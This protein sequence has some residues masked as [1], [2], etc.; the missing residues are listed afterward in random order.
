MLSFKIPGT[1][2]QA[3]YETSPSGELLTLRA[4]GKTY[5]DRQGEDLVFLGGWFQFSEKQLGRTLFRQVKSKNKHWCESY[6]WDAQGLLHMVDGTHIQR[7]EHGAITSCS[8]ERQTWRYHYDHHQLVAVEA[9]DTQRKIQFDAA[10]RPVSCTSAEDAVQFDYG[11]CGLRRDTPTP[12]AGWHRDE[13]GRLWTI[14]D[15]NGQIT[16]TYLWW[17]FACLA[18]IDGPPGDD[19]A[20]VFSLDPTGTPVRMTTPET[21]CRFT[22]DAFGESLLRVSGL[23]GLFGGAQSGDFVH[24]RSRVLD[25]RIGSFTATDPWHGGPDDPRREKGF[26]GGLPVEMAP[27]G[28]YCV[29]QHDPVARMDPTGEISTATAA[30]FNTFFEIM[31]SLTWGF[32][33]NLTG[34]TLLG[35]WNVVLSLL[36]FNGK[37][38]KRIGDVEG[39]RS[40]YTGSWGVRAHPSGLELLGINRHRAWTVQHIIWARGEEFDE[41]A[42]ARVFVPDA[43]F[44]PKLTGSLLWIKPAH[45]VK[46]TDPGIGFVLCGNRRNAAPD[47][48][49]N[50][51]ANGWTRSGGIGE[52]VFEGATAPWFPKGGLHFQYQKHVPTPV[53]G[54]I[55]E[56]FPTGEIYQGQMRSRLTIRAEDLSSKPAKG[57]V[58]MAVHKKNVALHT[59][60]GHFTEGAF[61][62]ILVEDAPTTL[63]HFTADLHEVDLDPNKETLPQGTAIRRLDGQKSKTKKNYTKDQYL[64]LEGPAPDKKIAGVQITGLEAKVTL[65]ENPLATTG[66]APYQVFQVGSLVIQGLADAKTKTEL[67]FDAKAPK[68]DVNDYIVIEEGATKGIYKVSAG[69]DA[70]TFTTDRDMLPAFVTKK[71]K[72]YIAKRETLLGNW[73]GVGGAKDITY[74]PEESGKA[75]S[76]GPVLFKNDDGDILGARNISALV[77]DEIILGGDLPGG[78]NPHEVT[79]IEK[80]KCLE[81]DAYIQD[82]TVL[83]VDETKARREALAKSPALQML[84]IND[85]TI[86]SGTSAAV[87]GGLVVVSNQGWLANELEISA[88]TNT[89]L[90]TGLANCH[91]PMPGQMVVLRE[92]GANNIELAIVKSLKATVTVANGPTFPVGAA[93]PATDWQIIPLTEEGLYFQAER[94]GN[95]EALLAPKAY[96]MSAANVFDASG[97][98]IGTEDVW[99]PRFRQGEMVRA[100]WEVG[101]ATATGFYRIESILGGSMKLEGHP[102]LPAA[103]TH[104]AFCKMVPS[105]PD[106]GTFV[107]GSD[108]RRLGANQFQ[109]SVWYPNAIPNGFYALVHAKKTWAVEVNHFDKL[110]IEFYKRPGFAAAGTPPKVDVIIPRRDDEPLFSGYHN[111]V[112]DEWFFAENHY[113]PNGNR[114]LIQAYSDP[115]AADKKPGHLSCGTTGIPSDD[116]DVEELDRR[117][118]LETH[119]LQHTAQFLKQG[120][121]VFGMIPLFLFDVIALG[122]GEGLETPEFSAFVDGTLT[123]ADG[124]RFLTIPNTAG[125]EFAKDRSVQV[126]QNANTAN[127]KLG[128]VQGGAFRI[129]NTGFLA[130]GQV[131]VRLKR[132]DSTEK[133]SKAYAGLELL[134]TGGLQEAVIG[135]LVNLIPWAIAQIVHACQKNPAGRFLQPDLFPATV[136]DAGNPFIIQVP[137]KDGDQ[138]GLAVHDK[139]EILVGGVR[140]AH[141]VVAV[142]GQSVTLDTPTR[143]EGEDRA[144]QVG[145]IGEQ[146]PMRFVSNFIGDH[147]GTRDLRLFFDPFGQLFF[148]KDPN[149]KGSLDW[150][151]AFLRPFYSTTSWSG[152]GL[153]GGFWLD[154]VYTTAFGEDYYSFMEQGASEESGDL[155]SPVGRLRGD[156]EYVGDLG[157]YFYYHDTANGNTSWLFCNRISDY[158][159]RL[160]D[161]GPGGNFRIETLNYQ[162]G[163]EVGIHWGSGTDFKNQFFEISQIDKNLAT[164]QMTLTLKTIPGLDSIGGVPA[165]QPSY[166]IDSIHMR[167]YASAEIIARPAGDAPGVHVQDYLRTMPSRIPPG[168]VPNPLPTPPVD[169]PNLAAG[170]PAVSSQALPHDLYAKNFRHPLEPLAADPDS[171][172]PSSLALVPASSKLQ[173]SRGMYVAF[174]QSSNNPHRLTIANRADRQRELRKG[175]QAHKVCG[176]T[177]QTLYFDQTVKDVEISHADTIL[178]ADLELVFCQRATLKFD[179]DEN[180]NYEITVLDPK[181]DTIARNAGSTAILAQKAKGT[182]LVE[183]ARVYDGK[184]PPTH[185]NQPF[186]VPIHH[187]KVNVTDTIALREEAD[188]KSTVVN[189]DAKPGD[190]FFLLVPA[191]LKEPDLKKVQTVAY[192]KN[193]LNSA[194]P[195]D[196]GMTPLKNGDLDDHVVDFIGQGKVY[197]VHFRED[198]P[199]EEEATYSWAI[200]V[201]AGQTY[202]PKTLDAVLKCEIK[203]KPFFRLESSP[204]PGDFTTPEG[205]GVKLQYKTDPNTFEIDDEVIITSPDKNIVNPQKRFTYTVKD[206]GKTL[207]LITTD[208][209][210]SGVYEILVTNKADSSQ[211]ARR[212]IEITP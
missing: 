180:R 18:R 35:F 120:P 175:R 49:S 47:V 15:G 203:I 90:P 146:H 107:A 171:Y 26:R 56:V 139:V 8:N 186:S 42:K 130:D 165:A 106:N 155:Y 169:E 92:H 73:N 59:V 148:D 12:Q 38:I 98:G 55:A 97:P 83:F 46:K 20:A 91:A 210:T 65:D 135:P 79:M 212:T 176:T 17:G 48:Q 108:G 14:T 61:T 192:T 154:I 16:T 125:I 39:M 136:P 77:T 23:P 71:V 193:P 96:R 196:S 116:S 104:L 4:G 205:A 36:S 41:L 206:G 174:S 24:Y 31:S 158:E 195:A 159:V 181:N 69:G 178:A 208:A 119:E 43:A 115:K 25:P 5:I 37:Q 145:K 85:A 197:E 21:T 138:H 114:V 70:N 82:R 84:R 113:L 163:D 51:F 75:P 93:A 156:V 131:A 110:L 161:P 62:H 60:R 30:G 177:R 160:T 28:P 209:I 45:G 57:Q 150:A 122:L 118:S 64:K 99:F 19:L 170:S 128:E 22:R 187:L 167:N 198:H 50:G 173:R 132:K 1:N 3:D 94:K 147:F 32:Q 9:P 129:T 13:F 67:K 149:D 112:E 134:T 207:E 105:S 157:R 124:F 63:R 74:V 27:A 164:R 11:E 204:T 86:T 143:Y 103:P 10:N 144:L 201:Q 88:F 2:A 80:G 137:P 33:N 199:P 190:K 185:L 194:K 68:P 53:K 58:V 6:V 141:V 168:P 111:I 183:I 211:K 166:F 140:D 76:D 7:N 191:K 200:G 152:V 52:P 127:G 100:V 78:L 188:H 81:S 44:R 133:L 179:P 202:A 189:R 126:V 29:C 182:T 89:E 162:V 172:S 95:L 101:G 184:N 54:T 40:P 109:F 66:P 34:I 142:N 102:N 117:Q 151:L 123:S 121:L 153:L 87:T 72:W